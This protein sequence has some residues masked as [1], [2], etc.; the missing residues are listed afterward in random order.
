[1]EKIVTVSLPDAVGKTLARS[2]LRD[3]YLFFK[4]QDGT[5]TCLEMTAG[6]DGEMDVN[7]VTDLEGSVSVHDLQAFGLITPAEVEARQ[8]ARQQQWEANAL[9]RER[10][11]FL[12]LKRKF[13]PEGVQ[14]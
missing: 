12:R 11:Q 14:P 1:M 8:L 5:I 2:E 10:E 4:W 13:E 7:E 9:A 6:Y 3:Q